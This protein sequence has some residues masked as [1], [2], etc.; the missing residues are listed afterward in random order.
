MVIAGAPPRMWGNGDCGIPAPRSRQGT[1]AK[2]VIAAIVLLAIGFGVAYGLTENADGLAWISIVVLAAATYG[3]ATYG[4]L[5]L[6]K[7]DTCVFEAPF[8]PF[9]PVTSLLC[10]SFL[11]SSLSGAA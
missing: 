4:A 7:L 10:N 3:V 11:M 1:R 6:K 5:T 8:F 2:I 9:L